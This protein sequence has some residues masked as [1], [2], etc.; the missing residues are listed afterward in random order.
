MGAWLKCNGEGTHA[1]NYHAQRSPND[2][3]SITNDEG[4]IFL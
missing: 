1:G 2:F 3:S 4:L